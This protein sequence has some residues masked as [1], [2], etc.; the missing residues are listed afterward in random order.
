MIPEF[1]GR[2]PVLAPLMP[3]SIEASSRSSPSPRT[4]SSASIST[5]SRLENAK[6]TFTDGALR[7]IA[8]KAAKRETGARA[9]R[10]VI[11]DLMLNLDVIELPDPGRAPVQA[12]APSPA[13]QALTAPTPGDAK[14]PPGSS[15]APPHYTPPRPAFFPS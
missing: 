14:A 9:L 6:L 2:L 1:V 3:L 10:A 5:S 11:E 7:K 8:E 12:R 15:F 13:V 4:R